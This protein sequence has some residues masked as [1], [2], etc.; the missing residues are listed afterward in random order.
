AS[1]KSPPAAKTFGEIQVDVVKAPEPKERPATE[2]NTMKTFVS[3]LGLFRAGAAKSN[4]PPP[5]DAS[6]PAGLSFSTAQPGAT[7]PRPLPTTP[8]FSTAIQ[9]TPPRA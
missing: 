5:S 7:A 4:P 2:Q 8:G 3:K 9:N 1:S 6:R